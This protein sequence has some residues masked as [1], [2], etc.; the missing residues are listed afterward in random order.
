[1]PVKVQ[2]LQQQEE[3]FIIHIINQFKK[4]LWN[5]ENENSRKDFV[6]KISKYFLD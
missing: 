6:Q 3:R 4:K 5:D 1:M 2:K